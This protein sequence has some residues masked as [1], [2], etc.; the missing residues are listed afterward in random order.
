MFPLEN[1]AR[2]TAIIPRLQRRKIL[3]LLGAKLVAGERERSCLQ[4]AK[5]V[6]GVCSVRV[7]KSSRGIFMVMPHFW[8]CYEKAPSSPRLGNGIFNLAS[9]YLFFVDEQQG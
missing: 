9:Q 3:L 4:P 5:T 2:F 7:H 1:A 8:C 6:N